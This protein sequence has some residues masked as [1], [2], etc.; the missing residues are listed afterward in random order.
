MPASV[1]RDEL[2]RR[3]AGALALPEARLVTLLGPG[4]RGRERPLPG[5]GLAGTAIPARPRVRSHRAS[6]PGSAPSERSSRCAS[7]RPTLG[8]PALAG[9]DPDELLTS[10]LLRRAARHLS[11]H[12]RQSAG[13]AP[14]DDDEL[15]RAVADLVERAGSGGSVTADKLEHSRLL[16]ELARLDREIASA[17]ALRQAG[18]TT[19]ARERQQVRDQLGHVAARIEKPH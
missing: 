4:A 11:A 15:S 7:P 10:E 12:A 1:L 16:L 6:S 18:I 17:R 2:T 3:A 5:S 9:I 8:G 14:A 19:L 13:R